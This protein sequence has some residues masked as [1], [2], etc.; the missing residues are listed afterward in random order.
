MLKAIFS[1]LFNQ[2]S[3]IETVFW[4]TVSGV[5]TSALLFGLGLL[6]AKVI[7]PW[8]QSIVYNGIKLTDTWVCEWTHETSNYKYVM[9]LSQSYHK[10]SGTGTLLKSAVDTRYNYLQPLSPHGETREGFVLLNMKSQNSKHLT[11]ITL[12]LKIIERGEALEGY[13]LYRS[14]SSEKVEA[15]VLKFTRLKG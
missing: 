10:I 2:M 14:A 12:M 4:G 6:F 7:V 9:N 15:E 8:Y 13:C 11:F 3:T 5:I 1:D